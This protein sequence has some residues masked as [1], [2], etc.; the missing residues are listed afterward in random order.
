M[1]VQESEKRSWRKHSVF[2]VDFVNFP[3]MLPPFLPTPRSLGSRPIYLSAYQC[4]DGIAYTF[5][6]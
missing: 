2:V 5:V 4:L 3:W 6:A 1:K